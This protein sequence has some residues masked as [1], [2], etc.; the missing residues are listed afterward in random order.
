[1]KAKVIV[2]KVALAA[3]TASPCRYSRFDEF[4]AAL[5]VLDETVF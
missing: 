3:P 4:G 1:L 2:I 5:T